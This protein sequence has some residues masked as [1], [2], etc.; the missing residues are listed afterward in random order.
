[1]WDMLTET[2]GATPYVPHRTYRTTHAWQC[3]TVGAEVFL[4]DL[5][6]D[7]GDKV[8]YDETERFRK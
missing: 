1:L 6:A 4:Q 7:S 8:S 2:P 5:I 3:Q